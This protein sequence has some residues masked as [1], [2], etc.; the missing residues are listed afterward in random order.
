[1]PR[2]LTDLKH[3][4]A[5]RRR[6]GEYRTCANC[7]KSFYMPPHRAKRGEQYCSH[8]CYHAK[9]P[10]VTKTC[11][12]CG[13][14]FTVAKSVAGRYSVCSREC[15]YPHTVFVACERCGN[16]FRGEGRGRTRRFCSE[17]CRRPPMHI[18]C[19][20]CGK[21][22][23]VQPGDVDRQF[24]SLACY[25]RSKGE[26]LLEK[27]VREALN[28]LG[29]AYIQEVRVGRYVVDFLLSA[30]NIALEADGDYWHRDTARDQRKTVYLNKHGLRVVR[31]RES[32]LTQHSVSDLLRERLIG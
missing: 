16:V 32:E 25:R 15:R 11:K 22:V 17:A 1:M 19:Q 9:R 8:E 12:V 5:E 28:A 10:K 24:C 4:P 27:Q 20:T 6:A 30:L 14:E 23:R 31:I 2:S 3:L 29:I 7:D 18:N 21:S 13:K 26:T